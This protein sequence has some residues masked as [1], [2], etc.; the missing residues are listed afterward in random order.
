MASYVSGSVTRSVPEI[1]VNSLD[2][3]NE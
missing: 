3:L 1:V 2:I